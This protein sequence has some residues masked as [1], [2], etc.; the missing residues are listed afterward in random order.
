LC[1]AFVAIEPKKI[2]RSERVWISKAQSS[3]HGHRIPSEFSSRGT[4]ENRSATKTMKPLQKEK[5]TQQ[6]LIASL[7]VI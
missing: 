4:G 7:D 6:Q 5:T 2:C 1:L 3:L